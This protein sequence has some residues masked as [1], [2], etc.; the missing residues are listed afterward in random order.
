L[1]GGGEAVKEKSG[2]SLQDKADQTCLVCDAPE[3]WRRWLENHHRSEKGVW[4]KIR[5]AGSAKP[6]V[7]LAEAVTEALCYGWIDS[8]MHALNEDSYA[9]RFTPRKPGSVWSRINRDRAEMLM[10]EGRMTEAGLK[11]VQAARE[12]GWWVL[13]YSSKEAPVCPADLM[14][15]LGA[16]TGALSS[17]EA[18]T[19]SEKSAAVFWIAQA[20]K[21]QTREKRIAEVMRLAKAGEKLGG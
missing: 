17:F 18:W 12:S 19:N 9:L 21:A 15:A 13:A 3:D 8:V 2:K 6:G 7:D 1:T 10:A 5:R 11:S 14:A 20:K 16:D 4:L